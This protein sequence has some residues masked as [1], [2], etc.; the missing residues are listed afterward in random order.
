MNPIDVVLAS[1]RAV[2]GE[3]CWPADRALEAIAALTD[4]SQAILGVELWRF[5]SGD[6]PT[7]LGWSDYRIELAGDWR[8]VVPLSR[9]LASD[10]LFG[11]VGDLD[12]WVNITWTGTAERD[13]V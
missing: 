9:S 13:E 8:D 4:L 11:H 3:Y 1:G 5:E 6:N 10:A 12:L 7:V 2:G